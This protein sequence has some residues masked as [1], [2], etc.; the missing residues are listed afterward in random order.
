MGSSRTIR[1]KGELVELAFDEGASLLDVVRTALGVRSA[2][3]GCKDGTCGTCRV[4]VDGKAVNACSVAFAALPSGVTVEA[5]E[6]VADS[7]AAARA[8]NAFTLERPTRCTLCVGALGV[9]AVALSRAGKTGDAE[10]ID[11]TLAN[12]TC[13]C[14]GRGSLRRA[15]LKG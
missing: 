7:P 14:T 9:T 12:A 15:L 8:V 6:D 5:Y 10:A 1:H 4:L 2:S 11:E 13:M 3:L